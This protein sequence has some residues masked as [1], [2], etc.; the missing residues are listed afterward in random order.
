MDPTV[1]LTSITVRTGVREYG[2]EVKKFEMMSGR[3][4]F[5]MMVVAVAGL[6]AG[7]IYLK[8]GKEPPGTRN[9]PP[10]KTRNVANVTSPSGMESSGTGLKPVAPGKRP[11]GGIPDDITPDQAKQLLEDFFRKTPKMDERKMFASALLRKLCEA[12]FS[13]EAWNVI[14]EELSSIR[15]A[16]LREYFAHAELAPQDLLV[17]IGKM[18][19][20]ISE[21]FTG[22]LS[23]FSARELAGVLSSPDLKNLVTQMGPERAGQ[24]QVS[25]STG[26]VLKRQL[27]DD[28]AAN[29]V[30][31]EVAGELKAKGLLS[32]SNYVDVVIQDKTRD[33]FQKWEK[34][35]SIDL[36]TGNEKEAIRDAKREII[37]GMCQK[38]SAGT[39]DQLLTSPQTDKEHNI[40]VAVD[41]WLYIDPKTATGWYEENRFKLHPQDRNLVAAAFSNEMIKSRDFDR[42]KV[43]IEQISD[44]AA[45]ERAHGKVAEMMEKQRLFDE[46]KKNDQAG[47]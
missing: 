3:V 11:K 26:G 19:S 36:G 37:A 46:K 2:Q 39:I 23:R 5:L 30:V 8:S 17:K 43:W 40:G 47:K 20:D 33:D 6:G 27:S 41:Y 31:I 7:A 28:P 1:K 42:A 14:P 34:L 10:A 38:N 9:D 4:K 21:S 25:R 29:A 32:S 22:Y 35:R 45:R 44:P 15:S 16:M 18:D 12:G 13:E 24:L